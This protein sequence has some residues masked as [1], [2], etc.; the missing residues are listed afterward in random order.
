MEGSPQNKKTIPSILDNAYNYMISHDLDSDDDELVAEPYSIYVCIKRNSIS[1]ILEP[2]ITTKCTTGAIYNI[3][4]IV[5][6]QKIHNNI[7]FYPLYL[8]PLCNA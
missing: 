1:T 2:D 3:H 5:G 8:V 4:I 7:V 6:N